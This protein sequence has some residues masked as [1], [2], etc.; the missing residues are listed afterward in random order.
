MIRGTTAQFKFNIPY[1]KGEL[2]W[3]KIKFWQ[4]GNQGTIFAPL[5]ITKNL[6]HCSASDDSTELC[7]ELTAEETMRF[8]DKMK[9]K[10]QL[11]AKAKDAAVFASRP[12]L[13]TVYPIHD[14][15]FDP[16][17]DVPDEDGWRILDGGTI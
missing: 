7:I 9:A 14:D 13:I 3:A 6:E 11:R 12:Q 5:P 1:T 17:E 16:T 2:E 15:L 4:D 8:S 10:V